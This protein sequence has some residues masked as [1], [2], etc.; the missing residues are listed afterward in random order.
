VEDN[1]FWWVV[2]SNE[3]VCIFE[4]LNQDKMTKELKPYIEYYSNGNVSIKGQFNS[5][6]EQVGVWEWFYRNGNIRCRT[7]FK[8]GKE[9][10]IE[11][12]F[13]P[14]GNI[15]MRTPYKDGKIDGIEELFYPSGNI[16][17]RIPYVGGEEDGIEEVFDEQGNI[18]E[19]TLW[20]N[21]EVIETTKH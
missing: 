15:R 19:T 6:G 18:T 11:E 1:F 13:Y 21:G 16:Q 8:G 9:D 2:V 5:K 7:P 17:R 10:G 3:F 4:L 12:F 20:K 14:N